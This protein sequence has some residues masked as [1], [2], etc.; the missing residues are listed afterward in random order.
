MPPR[1]TL[2]VPQPVPS[3]HG[4]RREGPVLL[5]LRSCIAAKQSQAVTPLQLRSGEAAKQHQHA[6][7]RVRRAF[8]FF[9]N[10]RLTDQGRDLVLCLGAVPGA[11]IT[12]FALAMIVALLFQ[13]APA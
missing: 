10:H 3:V 5:R 4:L 13:G 9:W 7:A 6:T 2:S 11:I 8:A 12:G 1:V